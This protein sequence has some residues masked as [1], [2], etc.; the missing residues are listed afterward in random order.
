MQK[1]DIN[2]I[3][4]EFQNQLKLLMEIGNPKNFS[5]IKKYYY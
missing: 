4:S 2:L 5:K 3:R 1:Y